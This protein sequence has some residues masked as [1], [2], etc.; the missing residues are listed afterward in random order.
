MSQSTT[1]SLVGQPDQLPTTRDL[2]S[3]LSAAI[4]SGRF[5]YFA[6]FRTPRPS[7]SKGSPSYNPRDQEHLGNEIARSL[8]AQGIAAIVVGSF[9][10]VNTQRRNPHFHAILSERPPYTWSKSFRVEYGRRAVHVEEIGDQPQDAA[11]VAYYIAKQAVSLAVAAPR[12]G[13]EPFTRSASLDAATEPFSLPK[14]AG[15]P[16]PVEP[17]PFASVPRRI[18][19][20]ARQRLVELGLLRPRPPPSATR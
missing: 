2:V 4:G 16:A 3:S 20:A 12:P 17:I 1:K 19:A 10:S 8:A 14:F 9:Q 13:N 7:P 15:S 6:T 5:P 18:P 11:K